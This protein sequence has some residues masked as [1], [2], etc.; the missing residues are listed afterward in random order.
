[1]SRPF[2]SSRGS[3]PFASDLTLCLLSILLVAGP[4]VLGGARPWIILPLLGLS[5]ILLV[6]QALR[7]FR[8]SGGFSLDLIDLAVIAFTLYTGGLWLFSSAPWLSRMEFMNVLAYATVFFSARYG[9]GRRAHGITLLVLLVLVGTAVAA[10]GFY[11]KLHPEFLPYGEKLHL[12]YAPRLTGTY[13]CPNHFGGFLVMTTAAALALGFCSRLPW[14]VRILFFYLAGGMMA[15]IA[16]SLSRGSWLGLAAA[17]TV[18]TL[19]L[20][21]HRRMPWFWPAGGL[22]VALLAGFL[23]LRATPGYEDRVAEVK[24]LVS[25]KKEWESYVRV[26]LGRDALKI[27]E[28]Y[29]WTGTGPGTFVHWHP[30]YQGPAYPTLA[31]FTHNDY[32]NLLADYGAW[33]AVIVFFFLLGVSWKLFVSLRPNEDDWMETTL[34]CAAAAAWAA[35]LVH[36]IVDFN[37]HIPANA[38]TLFALAGLGLR[39]SRHN[40]SADK[41]P[42]ALATAV[43][44]LAVA[45]LFV[46]L[47]ILTGRGYYPYWEGYRKR[48]TLPQDRLI[49][50]CQQA[51]EADPAHPQPA[52]FLG[53]IHRVQCA[54]TINLEER[55][56]LG[57]QSL[58]WY[59]R[60]R[61]ANP[62]DDTIT[63]RLGM[64]LDHMRRSTEAYLHY[65]TALRAQPFNG[66][67]WNALGSHFWRQ[68]KLTDAQKAYENA[69]RCPMGG[70][71][72]QKAL[73]MLK[74]AQEERL[75]KAVPVPREDG[76]TIP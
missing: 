49:A 27:F 15:G 19:F 18:T 59:Q 71:D 34:L 7:L 9:I 58:V 10:F 61:T 69:L 75:K 74:A 29:P 24:R 11:L 72:A 20:I 60:A 25:S 68:G 8:S 3:S 21:R 48:D 38:I 22:A 30:R 47:I 45:G 32:L 4:L 16:F 5:A 17:L 46:Y 39:R 13:G 36:S 28:D 33:G 44:L 53:D 6:V 31:I 55:M 43:L 63:V 52:A 12:Y 37:L 76:P 73:P 57:R 42:L 56:K 65:Q 40:G 67:F 26:Q 64:V 35:L 54:R 50:L 23:L 1:M 41:S 51:A 66:F 62:L 70:Q 14:I 2:R